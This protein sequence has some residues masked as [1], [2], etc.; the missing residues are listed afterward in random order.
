MSRRE[1]DARTGE[2]IADLDGRIRAVRENIRDLTEQAAGYSGAAD[3]EL[4][5]QRIAQQ[6]EQLALLMRQRE[7]ITQRKA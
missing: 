6:E 5:S 7:E 3:D 1:E 4:A 2:A